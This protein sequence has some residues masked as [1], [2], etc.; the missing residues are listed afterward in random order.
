MVRGEKIADAMSYRASDCGQHFVEPRPLP[1]S[2]SLV[3]R[4]GVTRKGKP[5]SSHKPGH[6]KASEL[7][8]DILAD[9]FIPDDQIISSYQC[10][11]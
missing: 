6:P 4:G 11:I 2:A 5:R 10:D 8:G 9:Q 7:R 3:G 1:N